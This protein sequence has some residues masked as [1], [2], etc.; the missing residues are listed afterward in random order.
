MAKQLEAQVGLKKNLLH[1]LTVAEE[2][3]DAEIK[4]REAVR[5][6]AKIDA[7][8]NWLAEEQ[9]KGKAQ[10]DHSKN[11]MKILKQA[12]KVGPSNPVEAATA[13]V[14]GNMDG[15]LYLLPAFIIGRSLIIIIFIGC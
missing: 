8:N 12:V 15:N 1:K 6:Q 3:L 7:Y 13:N 2:L 10:D 9:Q 11:L 14:L 5:E 4:K